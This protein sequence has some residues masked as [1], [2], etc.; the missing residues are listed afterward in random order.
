MTMSPQ[1]KIKF[2]RKADVSPG[3]AMLHLL[4]LIN[5]DIT[6][7]FSQKMAELE[8][9]LSN[10]SREQSSEIRRE[11]EVKI[12]ELKASVDSFSLK[13]VDEDAIVDNLVEKI[14]IP[15][16]IPGHTPTDEELLVLIKKVMPEIKHGKTPTEEYLKNLIKSI[17]PKI[18]S[19]MPISEDY[20]K[21]LIIELIPKDD[22]SQ[23]EIISKKIE[24]IEKEIGLFK[25]LPTKR[26]KLHGGGDTVKAGSGVSII[27][28]SD[29]TKTISFSSIS[30]SV[31]IPT[32]VIDNSNTNFIFIQKPSII[33]VNGAFY[34]EGKGWSWDIPTLTATLDNP[35]G[36]GGDIYGII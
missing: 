21:E 8:V 3:I 22:D 6:A 7:I 9:K 16:A 29:G 25:K 13:E 4:D 5:T 24:Q 1:E 20:L 36:T 31:L 35:V 2:I 23:D 28:N 12:G 11:F 10:A 17:M 27:T 32:G 18:E 15:D 26:G 30:S 34:R 14:K 33:S 19:P